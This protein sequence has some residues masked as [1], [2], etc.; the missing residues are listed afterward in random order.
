MRLKETEDKK[1]ALF[2]AFN[3]SGLA[4]FLASLTTA[5]AL[6]TFITAE[7][8]PVADMGIYASLGV[9]LAFVY[10]L[11]LLPA[12]ISALPIRE[13]P[14]T[15]AAQ[16]GSDSIFY[17]SLS[18]IGRATTG[19][20]YIILTVFVVIVAFSI[21]SV[22]NIRFS[23]WP[24]IYFND[25]H[26]IRAS[27]ETIDQNLG[28]SINLEVLIDTGEPNGLYDPDLLKR[29]V[30]SAEYIQTLQSGDLYVG[31]AWSIANVVKEINMALNDND[32]AYYRV[33]ETRGHV[34]QQLLLFENTGSDDLE[35]FTDSNF[36]MSRLSMR[37]PFTEASDCLAFVDKVSGHFVETYP[38]A[39]ITI[40]GLR[41]IL[42]KTFTNAVVTMARSY[43]LAFLSVTVLM[44]F[45][46]GNLRIGILSMVPNLSPVVVVLGVMA[47][48]QIELDLF[49]M[50]VGSCVLGIIVDDTIHFLNAFIKYNEKERDIK[51]AIMQSYRTTGSA[52]LITTLALSAGFGVFMLSEMNNLS[53]FGLVVTIAIIL[54]LIAEFFVV[55]ALLMV[56]SKLFAV[57]NGSVE[58]VPKIR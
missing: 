16:S 29:M 41:V 43:I 20:P 7:V 44:I 6:F 56:F 49:T 55:P 27:T 14:K 52:I 3:H 17:R 54:A 31:K 39:E 48:L 19:H 32:P 25:E 30:D 57:H 53:D 34:A 12:M 2:F 45:F 10:T 5:I 51:K 33:P 11:I 37:V 22:M 50:L 38:D 58:K 4:I 9:M 47:F 26:P 18:M 8:G 15:R 36:S 23:Y 13:K 24:L 42:N 35:M 21:I 46:L 28:G 40:T 1:D